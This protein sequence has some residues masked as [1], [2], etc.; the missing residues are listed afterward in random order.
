LSILALFFAPDGNGKPGL[1]K[2]FFLDY[3]ERPVGSSFINVEKRFFEGGLVMHS[4]LRH[5]LKFVLFLQL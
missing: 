1:K 5:I 3:K 4:W 2:L